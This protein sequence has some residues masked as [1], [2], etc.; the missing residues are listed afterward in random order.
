MLHRTRMR[1]VPVR[2]CTVPV[3]QFI[4]PT[5][6]ACLWPAVY[7]AW[8]WGAACVLPVR[9]CPVPSQGLPRAYNV[10]S[11]VGIWWGRASGRQVV[12]AC[13]VMFGVCPACATLQRCT[14]P[15]TRNPRSPWLRL[16]G[17]VQRLSVAHASQTEHDT[18]GGHHLPPTRMTPCRPWDGTVAVPPK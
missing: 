18:A 14:F 10:G 15:R 2:C 7:C 5:S 11:V 8:F 3:R 13:R 16:R 17:K 1:L 6:C 9:Y 4:F 12:R